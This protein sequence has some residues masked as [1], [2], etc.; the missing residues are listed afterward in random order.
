MKSAVLARWSSLEGMRV[1]GCIELFASE[2]WK[3][4]G[5]SSWEGHKAHF[6]K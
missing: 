3:Q 5:Q 4:G 2:L 1:K 6:C